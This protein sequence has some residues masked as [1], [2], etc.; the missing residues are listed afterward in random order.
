MMGFDLLIA[1]LAIVIGAL[2]TARLARGNPRQ[3][4]RVCF[5]IFLLSSVAALAHGFWAL[6]R[7]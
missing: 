5:L 7:M 4:N 1:G 3:A 6:D 2:L